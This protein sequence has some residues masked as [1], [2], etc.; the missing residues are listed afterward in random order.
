MA[1]SK[2][3]AALAALPVGFCRCEC[4]GRTE[5]ATRTRAD[6]GWVKG[7]PKRYLVGHNRATRPVSAVEYEEED[8]GHDTPCWAWKRARAGGRYGHLS[9]DGRMVLAHRHYY[10][11]HRGPI[12][13]GFDLDHLC[14]VIECVN[15]WHLEP[16][17]N[18]ENVR[19]GLSAVLTHRDAEEIKRRYAQG[20]VTQYELA[21]EYGI[22][23]STVSDVVTLSSWRNDDPA[24]A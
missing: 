2:S 21:D 5:I 19:R 10:E 14:R 7:E 6:R 12:P 16:V 4:G 9:V 3:E 11:K 24:A 23:Q 20:G 13:P 22:D 18:A 15:P 8:R 17:S 1:E